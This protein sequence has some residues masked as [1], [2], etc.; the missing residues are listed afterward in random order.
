MTGASGRPAGPHT[1][2]CEAGRSCTETLEQTS[3][4]RVLCSERDLAAFGA[5]FSAAC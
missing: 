3:R 4:A 5:S 1:G 2:G